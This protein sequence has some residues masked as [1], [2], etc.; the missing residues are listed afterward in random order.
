MV[1]LGCS[2]WYV[3]LVSY[4]INW[5]FMALVYGQASVQGQ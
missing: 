1:N 2:S 3:V 4:D 5:T